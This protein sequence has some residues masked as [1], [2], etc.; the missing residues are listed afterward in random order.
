MESSKKKNIYLM[1][2]I[3][4]AYEYALE[5]KNH[6]LILLLII[7]GI[8]GLSIGYYFY[9]DGLQRRAQKDLVK[10]VAV[11]QAPVH[12]P[13]MQS[14]DLSLDSEF[15]TSQEEKWTKV[16]QNFESD[17]QKNKGA[18]I[19]PMFLAYQAEA[20]INLGKLDSAIQVLKKL[21]SSAPESVVKSFYKVKLA[22]VSIDSGN[23]DLEKEGVEILKSIGL[24]SQNPAHPMALYYLGQYYWFAKNFDEAKNYW[25]QLILKYGKRTERASVWAEK[26]KVYLKLISVK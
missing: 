20:L 16:A 21:I 19:A 22:L 4:N 8:I 18:G 2:Y 24:E 15:F 17:Y 13:D 23:K 11:L 12:T 6:L 14:E 25:N 7:L 1:D 5:R 10:D 9:Q 26:A 3:K